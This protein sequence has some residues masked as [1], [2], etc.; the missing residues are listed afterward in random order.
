MC[1]RSVAAGWLSN[2]PRLLSQWALNNVGQ[3]SGTPD[4]DIDAPEAWEITNGSHDVVVG[5]IDTGIDLT[6]PD[7]AANIWRNPN[8][9]PGNGIDDDNNGFIDDVHGWD[10]DD[11]D[12]DLVP[13]FASCCE[14]PAVIS[15]AAT[16][17]NDTLASFSNYGGVSVDLAAPGVMI[18]STLPGGRYGAMCGTSMAAPHV[19][20]T[21]ALLHA[22]RPG[23]TL[24]EVRE[25]ILTTVDPLP[26]LGSPAAAGSTP[27]RPWRR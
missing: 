20:A 19:T 13:R 22:A 27:R 14:L 9:I 12:N 2:D 21:V 11:N 23:L 17:H 8:E 6:H 7:L 26:E 24:S 16:D 10:F 4:A 15:V 5:V 3:T 25:A 18:T 1:V